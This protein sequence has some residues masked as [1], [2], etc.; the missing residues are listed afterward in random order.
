MSAEE[1]LAPGVHQEEVFPKLTPG[2][3]ARIATFAHERSYADGEVL[4]EQGDRD[5]PLV[6]VVEGAI[7]ILPAKDHL[8]T[9][10]EPGQF[11]GDVDILS[12]R[13]AVVRG[14]A[15]GK[16]RVLE[17]PAARVIHEDLAHGSRRGARPQ[18]FGVPTRERGALHLVEDR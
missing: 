5:R 4:W 14:I 13:P 10:H 18:S 11:S 8:V 1:P 15:R 17:V 2:Q 6:V 3:Q 12:G 9:V 7:A 16:T